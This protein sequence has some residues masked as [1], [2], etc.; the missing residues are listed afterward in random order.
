MSPMSRRCLTSSFWRKEAS[1]GR[2]AKASTCLS[3]SFWPGLI[4]M[5]IICMTWIIMN[6]DHRESP[7][8]W[9]WSQ[10]IF[11]VYRPWN[12]SSGTAS[13]YP[14]PVRIFS[15]WLMIEYGETRGLVS[16]ESLQATWLGPLCLWHSTN[17]QDNSRSTQVG[18]VFAT[19][20]Q[21]SGFALEVEN[22]S[23]DLHLTQ[24]D[25]HPS[26]AVWKK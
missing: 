8:S 10:Q 3:S 11:P 17:E 19:F 14:P 4:T 18:S 16:L 13:P 7:S 25:L 15:H 24:G 5:I 23:K 22:I 12:I 9:L 2:A 20:S 1:E 26:A 21:T 6:Y